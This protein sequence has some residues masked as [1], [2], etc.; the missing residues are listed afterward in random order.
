M[1]AKFQNAKETVVAMFKKNP[2]LALSV[3]IGLVTA[4]TGLIKA[5]STAVTSTRN[6]NTW[7]R[8]VKRR[9]GLHK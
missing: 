2:E 8:E 5:S 1:K 3:T 4:L 7:R 9:E 6:S